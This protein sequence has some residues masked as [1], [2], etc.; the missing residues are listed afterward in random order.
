MIIPL[1]TMLTIPKKFPLASVIAFH[2]ML[3][4]DKIMVTVQREEQ[5]WE[6][7][8]QLGSLVVQID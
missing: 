3:I 8:Q 4:I 2:T 1:T 6:L 5:V 7:V